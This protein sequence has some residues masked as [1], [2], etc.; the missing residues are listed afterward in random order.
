MNFPWTLTA[1]IA[2]CF[3]TVVTETSALTSCYYNDEPVEAELAP[4]DEVI[5][6]RVAGINLPFC[7]TYNKEVREF[8]KRYTVIG[9]KESEAMLGRTVLYFPIFEHYLRVYKLPEELKYLPMV[10]STLRP[11]VRS[12]AGAAGLWQFVPTAARHFGL[13]MEGGV[14]ERLDPYR[15]TEAAVKMLAALYEEFGDWM[16]VMAAFNSGSGRVKKAICYANSKDYWVISKY[17]P[18]E[19]RRYVPSFIAAAY[20]VNY[21]NEHNLA[22]KYPSYQ[23][24]ETRTF[25]VYTPLTFQQ[26]A[27]VVGVKTSVIQALNPSY[28]QQYVPAGKNGHFVI[29][30]A[31]G[32]VAFRQFL[33][34]KAGVSPNSE[35]P[36]G[37]FKSSYIVVPG[38]RI[39]SVAM[40]FRCDVE[41]LM[42]WNQLAHREVVVNQYLQLF[43]PENNKKIKP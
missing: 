39:E 43:L 21:F 32:A 31:S 14:D 24:Q 12:T 33:A 40:L 5:K 34:K 19:S 1:V 22:P 28:L 11:E 20:L 9:V 26:I 29:V 38:D 36:Q 27:Q 4:G 41:D 7:A 17:L 23:M 35:T 15:S 10:E 25:R 37:R 6:A 13:K 30:P 16:L 8:I 42:K 2:A 3:M 18:V